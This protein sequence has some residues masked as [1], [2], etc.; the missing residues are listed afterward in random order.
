MQDDAKRPATAMAKINAERFLTERGIQ[1]SRQA[2]GSLFVPNDIDLSNQ[3]LTALPDLSMVD[4]G[5][6]FYCDKNQLTDLTGAPRSVQG[7]FNCSKN[8]L[9]SLTGAPQGCLE[10]DCSH[11]QLTSLKGAPEQLSSFFCEGNKLTSLEHAPAVF[12]TLESDFGIYKS[13][14]AVPEELQVSAETR[15]RLVE[16]AEAPIRAMEQAIRCATILGT[17]IQVGRALRFRP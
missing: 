3:G 11:N 12:T 14:Q 1:Y 4:V 15:Q 13:W 9:T 6:E 16:E 17:P 5:R 10:F 7:A 2:D 8:A